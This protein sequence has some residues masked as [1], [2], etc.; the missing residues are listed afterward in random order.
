MLSLP[1][2]Q[3]DGDDGQQAMAQL[4]SQVLL[5]GISAL[6]KLHS[7]YVNGTHQK[8]LK[9]LKTKGIWNIM[10]QPIILLMNHFDSDWCTLSIKYSLN[11]RGTCSGVR[12]HS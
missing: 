7:V 3:E 12:Q 8:T 6:V 10:R 4:N 1:G 11:L 5:S 9:C 2:A